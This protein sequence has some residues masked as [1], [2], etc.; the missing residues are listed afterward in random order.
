MGK[1]LLFGALFVLCSATAAFP[2]M[3]TGN[4]L[5]AYCTEEGSPASQGICVGYLNGVTEAIANLSKRVC[6]PPSVTMM[7]VRDVVV[8]H[9]RKN[10]QF[11]HIQ[12]LL[13]VSVALSDAFPCKPKAK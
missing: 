4:Q 3:L 7:Q 13:L 9:M 1:Q 5:Y 10:A 8:Q 12:A 2:N 11:R 6:I